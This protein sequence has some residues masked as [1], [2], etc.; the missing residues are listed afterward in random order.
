MTHAPIRL[1]SVMRA[2]L[3]AGPLFVLG[4]AIG[5]LINDPAAAIPVDL[6]GTSIGMILVALPPALV[7][8]MI[9]GSMIAFLPNLIGATIMAWLSDYN[10]GMYLPVAWAVTG[11]IM[12]AASVV[13]VLGDDYVPHPIIIAAFAFTGAG[14]ALIYRHGLGKESAA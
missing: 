6:D 11:G 1:R 4:I 13:M 8:V 12:S 2:T 5:A 7:L 9:I 10:E 14:C 3:A